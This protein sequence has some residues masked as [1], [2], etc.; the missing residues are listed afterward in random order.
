MGMFAYKA[1]DGDGLFKTGVVDAD[2]LEGAYTD[3]ALQGLN[4]L[5]IKKAGRVSS[6][7]LRGFVSFRVK[8]SA[9]LEF[10]TNLSVILRAGIPILDALGDISQTTENKYL[11]RA[12]EDIKERIESGL[13][14]SS[15]LNFHKRIF[16]DIF[17]RLATV[18]EETGRLEQSISEVAEHLQRMDDLSQMVKRAL[19]YPVFALVTTGGAL[20]FWVFYVLPK[21]MVVMKDMNIKL[22]LITRFMLAASDFSKSYWYLMVLAV[23]AFFVILAV[24]KRKP[25]TRYFIDYIKLYMPIVKLFVVNRIFAVFCEQMRI[26]IVSGITID[27]SLVIVANAVGSEVYKRI[28][29]QARDLIITGS[30]ISDAFRHS[31]VFHP[32][33]VRMVDIGE[34]SGN[35]DDQFK[36]L[37][38]FFYKK[39]ADVTDKLG[40]MIEPILIVLVGCIF[41]VIIIGL[42]LPIYDIVTK[43][44]K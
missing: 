25:K 38:G 16:P 9:M 5:S 31:G 12:V 37:S 10:A 24:M 21:I 28:L 42:L 17:I 40:K 23:V 14:F 44:E 4:V 33:V 30:R 7:F 27:R 13:S 43:M 6:G 18:G 39:L 2:D 15:A 3:P 8:R 41:A 22:P 1:I 19:I 36:F 35:L 26:L 32:L 34:S 20:G 29:M 11:R